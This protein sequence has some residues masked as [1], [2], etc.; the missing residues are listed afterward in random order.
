VDGEGDAGWSNPK[1]LT[2]FAVI[3]LCGTMAGAVGM[4]EF[5]HMRMPASD[6]RMIEAARS[7]PP[8]FLATKLKLTA[9]QKKAVIG[10]LDEYAKYYQNIEEERSDVARHGVQAIM[11][12]LNEDQRKQFSKMFGSRR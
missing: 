2:I 12:C 7:L 3:F 9:D 10:Q 6:S 4:R 11:D 1:V 8:D 5:M